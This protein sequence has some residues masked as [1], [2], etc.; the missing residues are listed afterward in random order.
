[1]P[2]RRCSPH[3]VYDVLVNIDLR[4]IRRLQ[5][6]LRAD[7]FLIDERV[8]KL[9]RRS[10]DPHF[11]TRAKNV[12]EC[13]VDAFRRAT[14]DQILKEHIPHMIAPVPIAEVIDE[15]GRTISDQYDLTRCYSTMQLIGLEYKVHDAELQSQE[16]ERV[17]TIRAAFRN[18]G[19]KTSDSSVF[20]LPGG[21]LKFIDITLQTFLDLPS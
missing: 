17:Q 2:T 6:G 7:V 1:M 18:L 21:A 4:S 9:C 5:L 3:S 20:L 14:A 15:D 10:G 12:F 8:F 13:Q 11:Y 16:G 19:I